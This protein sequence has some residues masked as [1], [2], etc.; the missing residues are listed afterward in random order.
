MKRVKR[1]E[2]TNKVFKNFLNRYFFD[3][4]QFG[5]TTD[6]NNPMQSHIELFIRGYC[7]SN[8]EYCYLMKQGKK[9]YPLEIQSDENLL[10]NL[11]I[12]LN[13]YSEQR[14]SANF[15]LFS[16]RM[17]DTDLGCNVLKTIYEHFSKPTPCK[18]KVIMIPDD[19]QFLLSKE[20]TLEIESWIEKF[21]AAGMKIL[22]SAS[23]DGKIIDHHR[24]GERSDEFYD[25]LRNFMNKYGYGLH[26]MVAPQNI[27]QWIENWDWLVSWDEKL[28]TGAMT[29][30]V[31]NDE[32]TVERL[33]NY[34]LYL[35]HI[36][37]YRI[38][39][40]TNDSG[41]FDLEAFIYHCL[42]SSDI[43]YKNIVQ[44]GDCLKLPSPN[45][46]DGEGG[47][48]C[49]VQH[50]FCVRLGDLSIPV[51]HRT[52]YEGLIGG[53]FE[54][55]EDK[56]IDIK[57]SNPEFYMTSMSVRNT[58]LP[59]CNTCGLRYN[60]FLGCLGSN[61]ESTGDPYWCPD[62]VCDMLH[63]KT[64]F[65][66]TKLYY[67]GGLDWLAKNDKAMMKHLSSTLDYMAQY[68]ENSD[69]GGMMEVIRN[70]AKKHN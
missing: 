31:R 22:F 2:E 65:I 55:Q 61:Y 58:N 4:F 20:R 42:S 16:G 66:L 70:V 37:N 15:E 24:F 64:F 39:Y 44:G 48:T 18:P 38:K 47:L 26:P 8:C 19:M 45:G 49:S 14:W 41:E 63:I 54:V 53:Y 68:E 36:A 40:Y 17:F 29:L 28:A 7:P 12:F 35:N 11:K 5:R 52:A 13:Y 25:T 59:K 10:K 33:C 32:W 6:K 9:L 51:C 62:S 69:F 67:L 57:A 56:I 60:C 1:T 43:K 50:G 34:I 23:V 27:H 3:Y 21:A 46:N 30:E